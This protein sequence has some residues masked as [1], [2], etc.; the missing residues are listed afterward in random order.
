MRE[1]NWWRLSVRGIRVKL[2]GAYLIPVALIILLGV[3]SYTRASDAIITKYEE[4]T[5]NT[6]QKTAEYYDLLMQNIDAKAQKLSNDSKIRNYYN[7]DLKDSPKDENALYSAI[8]QNVLSEKTSDS[9]IDLITI[10]AP[11]GRSLTS[12][13]VFENDVYSQ[14]KDTEEGKSILTSPNTKT[15]WSGYHAFL[16][17]YLKISKNSYG[18]SLSRH[19]INNKMETVGV[20]FM[21]IKT[22]AI[23]APL[24]TINLPEGSQCA[25]VISGGREIIS[26]GENKEQIFFGTDFYNNALKSSKST[27]MK[28]ILNNKYL[29]IYAKVG[30]SGSILCTMIPKNEI[31]KQVNSI[32]TVTTSVVVIA[33]IIAALVGMTLARGIGNEIRNINTIV[34][35][36]EEGDLTAVP[37]TKRKDEFRLL[38]KYITGM[39][40]GMK[41]LVNRTAN[42]S[43]TIMESAESVSA[44]SS[45]LVITSRNITEVVSHIEAGIEQQAEDAQKCLKKMSDLDEKINYVNIST[46][47]IS[48]FANS[49]KDIVKNGIVTMDELGDKAKA[50]FSIAKEIIDNIEHLNK[51]SSS[52]S[53]I[54]G[55]INSIADQTN[56]LALN[57]S[58]EA[59][60]AGDAGKGF[61]V[62]ATEIRK[63]A[64]ESMKASQKINEIIVSIQKRTRN[65]AH[66][67]NE[68]EDIVKSQELALKSTLQVFHNITTHVDGL[69]NNIDEISDRIKDIEETK[70]ITLNA[71]TDISS[72]LEETASASVEVQSAAE[73]QLNATQYLNNAVGR[74]REESIELQSA[75]KSFKI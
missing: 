24:E 60:R 40:S 47:Q 61:A 45:E 22:K 46:E 38:S 20:L 59:A 75:V 64:D 44:A 12:N 63:L 74:L 52:I 68:A 6:I 5:K 7:G 11:Y 25:L 70:N 9:N 1:K 62:V 23:Q 19:I 49:T 28:Y 55:T 43:N 30:V 29:F 41:A 15:A 21:D 72:V 33:I 65:T 73:S 54:T 50:T 51:E 3:L 13:G 69:I 36:A 14:F 26:R 2:V 58:I 18:I 37:T 66:T 32:K 8:N 17:D 16:D 67:A 56:L 57:A 4:A 71:I 48:N 27:D 53:E 35:R 42:V 10:I 34:K 39:L 31:L